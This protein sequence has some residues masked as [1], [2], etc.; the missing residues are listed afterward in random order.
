M[1]DLVQGASFYSAPVADPNSPL[2]QPRLEEHG[3][4]DRVNPVPA[5]ATP[6]PYLSTK[7]FTDTGVDTFAPSS[8]AP[9][10]PGFEPQLT[11]IAQP[12]LNPLPVLAAVIFG[13]FIFFGSGH[14]RHD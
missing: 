8:T 6:P 1:N 12:P 2:A 3:E 11:P 10:P 13:A 9:P 4:L 5:Q 7:R 14:G